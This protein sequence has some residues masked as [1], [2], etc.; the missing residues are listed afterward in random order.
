MASGQA[1]RHSIEEWWR[2]EP[3]PPAPLR[4]LLSA[5]SLLYRA[6]RA[7]HR[8]LYAAGLKRRGRLAAPVVSVGN[9]TV[10]GAGKTP[11]VAWLACEL[12]RRGRSVIVLGRGYGRAATAELNEEGEW[13]AR[14]LPPPLVRVVQAPDRFRAA[15]L[16]LREQP[17]DVVLLDDGFQHEALVRDLDVVLVDASDPFGNGRLLPR[18][19][20]REPL[21]ALRRAHFVFLTR[22]ELAP[23]ERLRSL[24]EQVAALAP[25]ARL[26]VVRFEVAALRGGGERGP[27]KRL[28]GRAVVLLTGVGSP[29]AVRASVERLGARVAE[30]LAFPDHHPFTRAEVERALARARALSAELVVTSKDAVKL[31]RLGDAGR[32]LVLEQE[33]AVVEGGERLLE[34][35]LRV[36]Q[37]RPPAGSSAPPG[38]LS[39]GCARG[40]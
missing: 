10:G 17:A 22:A 37:R 25:G 8:G 34:E 4:A 33:P 35:L 40:S 9:L 5:A 24:K 38:G 20:L 14:L 32:Y 15:Q 39:L 31:D 19:P 7:L 23:A 26:G 16:A 30:E 27:P 12:S 36:S 11:F 6:G 1:G 3:P 18:G 2:D 28:A 21:A 29:R 13:L